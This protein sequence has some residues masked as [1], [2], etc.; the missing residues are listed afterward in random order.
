ML[1]VISQLIPHSLRPCYLISSQRMP[2]MVLHVWCSN[3]AHPLPTLESAL[4]VCICGCMHLHCI[5]R[6]ALGSVTPQLA[7]I[8]TDTGYNTKYPYW[9][10]KS[11]ITKRLSILMYRQGLKYLYNWLSCFLEFSCEGRQFAIHWQNGQNN[12]IQGL[13]H[14][15]NS[16][17]FSSLKMLFI[18]NS[19]Y[20]VSPFDILKQS[21]I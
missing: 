21:L 7:G 10:G 15:R 8:G 19:M 5:E 14:T 4:S 9:M 20:L 2:Y 18:W 13:K 12:S 16:T 3:L 6:P 1:R 17:N 11:I